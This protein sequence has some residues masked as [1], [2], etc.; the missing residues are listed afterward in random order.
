MNN[1]SIKWA[2]DRCTYPLAGFQ[3][4]AATA[5][6]S[7]RPLAQLGRPQLLNWSSLII[8]ISRSLKRVFTC[9]ESPHLA[10]ARR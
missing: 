5:W 4:Q 1:E 3:T 10:A 2:P 8:L 6:R 9:L 7:L